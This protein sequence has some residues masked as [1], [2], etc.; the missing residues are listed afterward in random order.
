MT[1]STK[2]LKDS[3]VE[4]T[5]DLNK[6]DL[7]LYTAETEK[8]LAKEIKV[9]GFRPGKA[10]KEIARKKIM[11]AVTDSGTEV[12]SGADKP[13]LT[14]L[15]T[16]YSLLTGKTIKEIEKEYAGK[17]Y[18]DFKKGLAD[19]VVEFLTDF[20]IKFNA[21]NDSDVRAILQTGAEKARTM[22]GKKMEKVRKKMGLE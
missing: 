13:A 19:V 8:R 16:I 5:I 12:K 18:A 11:R 6:E 20:Q 2:N 21:L 3:Q 4:L 10:P 22:A 17:G 1:F 9:E 7:L 15:L 14:N